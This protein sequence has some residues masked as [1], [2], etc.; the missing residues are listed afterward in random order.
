MHAIKG[1]KPYIPPF[2][3]AYSTMLTLLFH[4]VFPS[5]N[6]ILFPY[7]WFGLLI[8][9]TGFLI[10]RHI[11]NTFHQKKTTV[12]L[13][14]PTFLVTEG[15]FKYSRNPMYIGMF[16]LLMGNAIL[17]QNLLSVL[18]PFIFISIVWLVFVRK[19]EKLL[20]QTFGDEYV[21]YKTRVRRWL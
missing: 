6:A 3:I 20:E 21:A 4:F 14:E 15:I 19:E 13:E 1:R 8:A 18:L 17:S 16:M 9:G 11:W 12:K 7:N 5:L 10:I 2:L